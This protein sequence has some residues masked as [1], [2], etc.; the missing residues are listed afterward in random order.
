MHASLKNIFSPVVGNEQGPSRDGGGEGKNS[1]KWGPGVQVINFME[2]GFARLHAEGDCHNWAT[3]S[4][5]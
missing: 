1:L 3:I 5:R 4:D 2:A